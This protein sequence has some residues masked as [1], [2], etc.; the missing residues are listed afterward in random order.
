LNLDSYETK[1][2]IN[3]YMVTYNLIQ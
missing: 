1:I 2:K 3:W